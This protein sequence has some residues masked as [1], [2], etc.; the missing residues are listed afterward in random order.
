MP[1]HSCS[2]FSFTRLQFISGNFVSVIS[3]APHCGFDRPWW[4]WAVAEV[5]L[6][7][8]AYQLEGSGLEFMGAGKGRRVRL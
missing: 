3:R 2:T 8:L 7:V 5:A 4:C 6:L 1:R